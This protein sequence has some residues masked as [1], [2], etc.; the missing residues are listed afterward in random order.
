MRI[1]TILTTLI[2]CAA[3]L[4][5]SAQTSQRLSAGKASEYGLVYSLPITTV[6]IWLEASLTEEK[7]GE[8][9]NYARRYLGASDAISQT[10][11]T[12]E[13]TRVIITPRA[14]AD[15]NE[16]WLAQFK[17]GSTPY[18]M[19]SAD[20]IPLSIN[21]E[22]VAAIAEPEILE[23]T[24][25]TE[26]AL[27]GPAAS[28]AVTAD[29]SRSSS[30]SKRAELAAQ[31]IFELREMRSDILS[32]QAD[33]MPSDGAA[34]QLVLDNLSAQESALTAMFIGTRRTR[35]VV[36][37][38]S[39][40]PDSL[41]TTGRIIARLSAIDGLITADNLA[42][43]PIVLDFKVLERGELP[44][45]EKG[46]IKSFP[47]GGVAYRIPGRGK[48]NVSYKG[49]IIGSS[50]LGVAQLGV[51]FGLDPGLFTHKKEPSMVVFDPNTGGIL[52]LGPAL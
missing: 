46:E 42:G 6:D 18:M 5:T 11:N 52:T 37:K 28:Q 12:T 33:N 48:V 20:N 35:T 50:E 29:M 30:T 43:A 17:A 49:A 40:T 21:T 34:M 9:N 31:R 25:W 15:P 16:Q 23:S 14:V 38:V 27:D 8:F 45:T 26:T 19:I 39:F 36:K 10:K 51:V 13:L 4:T 2:A 1:K 3:V 24:E 32:G 41:D 44:R 47:K 22:D 7:P